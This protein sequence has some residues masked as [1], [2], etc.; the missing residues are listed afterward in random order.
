MQA[1]SSSATPARCATCGASLAAGAQ[2]CPSC[3]ALVHAARLDAISAQAKQREAAGD[4]AGARA[5]WNEA[6]ILLPPDSTQTQWVRGHLA[7]LPRPPAEKPNWLRRLGPLGPFVLVIIK[8]K[9]LFLAIFKLK[10]LFSLFSFVAVYWALYGWKFGIGFAVSILIHEMGHYIDIKR[11]GLPAEMPVFLPGL[12]AYVRWQ[13][14]GVTQAQRAQISLAGPLAGWIAAAVCALLYHQTHSMLWASLA[15][16]GAAINVMNLIPIWVLDGG[17]A[18]NALGRN[19]RLALM[20]AAVGLWWI[21]GE[22]IFLFVAA[23]AL[24]RIFTI[25]RR[26]TDDRPEDEGWDT[27]LYYV[28]VMAALALTLHAVPGHGFGGR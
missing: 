9:G 5:L 28:A 2:A 22:G 1:I 27:L 11:R 18:A 26:S 16:A 7:A 13:A 12:G 8:G 6:L 3:H 24:W 4:L 19:A 21:G 10:F 23:G 25:S 17:Q 15:R 14:L 20:T